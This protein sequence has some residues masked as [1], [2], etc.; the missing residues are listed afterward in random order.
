[1]DRPWVLVVVAFLY[2]A[3]LAFIV[4]RSSD[5]I[6]LI[7]SRST[8]R[9]IAQ[10]NAINSSDL[11]RPP[12]VRAEHP[13]PSPQLDVRVSKSSWQWIHDS[14]WHDAS[15][16][17]IHLPS[18]FLLL[19][20]TKIHNSQ[21]IVSEITAELEHAWK[22]A[23]HYRVWP[24]DTLPVRA[25]SLVAESPDQGLACQRSFRGPAFLLPPHIRDNAHHV[26]N[27][28]MLKVAWL[29]HVNKI[30]P[31]TAT[32]LLF[33]NN[34]RSV[35]VSL[36]ALLKF[37][38]RE[39][40]DPADALLRSAK[41]TTCFEQ[42][43]WTPRLSYKSAPAPGVVY[44]QGSRAISWQW[45]ST[46]SRWV[47]WSW[48]G[49]GI[50]E[51]AHA[52]GSQATSARGRWNVLFLRRGGGARHIANFDETV[53][54]TL[55][56]FANFS[57]DIMDKYRSDRDGVKSEL[58]R[59]RQADV[60]IGL[61]G[62]G[63]AHILYMR[64]GSSAVE[65]KSDY[66]YTFHGFAM[67]AT[68][69]DVHYYAADLR[70]FHSSEGVKVTQSYVRQLGTDLGHRLTLQGT[71]LPPGAGSPCDGLP[72][73]LWNSFMQGLR[74]DGTLS[75]ALQD[76]C[77]PKKIERVAV[78]GKNFQDACRFNV[79]AGA[80]SLPKY[81]QHKMGKASDESLGNAV[82]QWF[83][84]IVLAQWI[85]ATVEYVSDTPP[86]TNDFVGRMQA[87]P[88]IPPV[89]TA[90]QSERLRLA[91][92]ACSCTKSFLHTCKE[93]R[94]WETFQKYWREKLRSVLH[95]IALQKQ[96]EA[97]PGAREQVY[98]LAVH[99]RCGD[100]LKY[101]FLDQ[102]GF[103][104]L[105]SYKKALSDRVQGLNVRII[106]F[107]APTHG[108]GARIAKD[109]QFEN[110]CGHIGSGLRRVLET[111]F[112]PA[113]VRIDNTSLSTDV[114]THLVFAKRTLCSPSTFCLW[115][116]MAAN[117]G[118]LADTPLFFSRAHPSFTNTVHLVGLPFL[119]MPNIVNTKMSAEQIVQWIA[120]H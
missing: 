98:D 43:F 112:A 17:P 53:R 12:V 120:S 109:G 105:S 13:S 77:R 79:V 40:V 19:N 1:M 113:Q 38:L 32:L 20:N 3:L 93:T 65:L 58:S 69:R 24:P 57:L 100:I 115:P 15:I 22:H 106:I 30:V 101:A 108:A 42:L 92:L 76:A 66:A 74:K 59:V 60:L 116:T 94:V 7:A 117:N 37:L 29:M 83:M 102:Y 70:K 80:S 14:F 10:A 61:H 39:V 36:Y 82:P 63:L 5:S 16:N 18:R 33:N 44:S 119:S 97:L 51:L 84:T 90:D 89:T 114:W 85:G 91:R 52:Q 26:H 46:V 28:L 56:S 6:N 95:D 34:D 54:S 4:T 118:F 2:S 27:D 81:F 78:Q 68:F 47:E 88:Y 99:V 41:V 45:R 62:A 72:V 110:F 21:V 35:P 71:A 75:A 55:L 50:A 87:E 73:P 48:S 103:L 49:M 96:A 8:S 9:P 25:F 104:G 23:G 86:A 107:M 64:A 111:Q 11:S 67:F 31:S